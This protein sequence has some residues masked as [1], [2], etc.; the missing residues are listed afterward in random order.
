MSPPEGKTEPPGSST[1]ETYTPDDGTTDVRAPE[2]ISVVTKTA[3]YTLVLTDGVVLVDATSGDLTMTL[4]T[5]ASAINRVFY[6][7]KID[8]SSNSVTIDAN[9]SETIDDSLTCIITM[10]Y[11]CPKLVSDGTEWWVI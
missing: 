9:G 5:A 6:I 8:S 7:K 11:D 2:V 10:Q 4:P 1:E 3:N